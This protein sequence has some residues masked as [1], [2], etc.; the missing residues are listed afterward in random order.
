MNREV[1]EWVGATDDA[2]IPPR[3][4]LRVFYRHKGICHVSGRK[5]APGEKW[6]IEHVI[7]LCNGG[8]HAESNLAPALREK[9]PEKTKADMA[10][11]KINN[12]V[13]MKHLGI[14]KR[15]SRPMPGSRDSGIKKR[16]DGTVERRK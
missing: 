16:M 6:D 11:K 8:R 7:A 12:R 15:K 10:E 9:H 2:K 4:K 1:K 3:V 14:R 5:I 13:R